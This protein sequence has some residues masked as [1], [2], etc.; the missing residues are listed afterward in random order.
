MKASSGLFDRAMLSI[1]YG[2]GL[3]SNEGINLDTS[4][5]LLDKNLLYVRKGKGYKER[6]VPITGS[7][8]ADFKLYLEQCR[9]KLIKDTTN[10]HFCLTVMAA[11]LVTQP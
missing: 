2:C 3:R 10:K 7:I 9:P 1:Y 11:V 4:D 8:H 5:V 6:Y